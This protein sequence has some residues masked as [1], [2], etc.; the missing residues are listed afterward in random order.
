MECSN[1]QE[2]QNVLTVLPFLWDNMNNFFGEDGNGNITVLSH[3]DCEACLYCT[4]CTNASLCL[5]Y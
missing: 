1:F 2:N 5:F 3:L 4:R